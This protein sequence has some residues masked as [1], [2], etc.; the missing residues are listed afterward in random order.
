MPRLARHLL[1]SLAIA[2]V[3]IA[4]AAPADAAARNYSDPTY[5]GDK[6][7]SCL[8]NTGICGKAAADQF[9]KLEGFDS[10]LTFKLEHN[11]ARINTARVLDSGEVLHSPNALPFLSVKCWRPNDQPTA[12]IFGSTGVK[13][14]AVPRTCDITADCRKQAADS[15]CTAKGYSLGATGYDVEPDDAAFASISCAAL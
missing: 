4:A 11:P 12:V 10:A 13:Q 3:S 9:C 6:I 2:F 1:P 5:L 15:F 8:A 14:L 7:H